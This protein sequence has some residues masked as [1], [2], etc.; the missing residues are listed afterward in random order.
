MTADQAFDNLTLTQEGAVLSIQINRPEVLNALD[1][2]TLNEITAAFTSVAEQESVRVV[3][4]GG[5]GRAFSAGADLGNPPSRPLPD[6]SFRLQRHAA[7]T[8][9]RAVQ[10]ITRCPAVTI[11]RTHSYV[12][13]GGVLLAVACDFRIGAEDSVFSLP[14]VRLGKPLSWGGTPLLIKEIGAAR[15]REMIMMCRPIEAAEAARIGL[16]HAVVPAT[17]LDTEVTRWCEQLIGFPDDSVAA[18]KQQF[19]RYAAATRLADLTETD[20]DIYV[21]IVDPAIK[22]RHGDAH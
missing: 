21:S 20:S 16:L 12:I 19:E 15:A 1:T 3:V 22:V 2:T 8:G 14:E 13:G 7:E 9:H 10:A 5:A 6:T 11:A 18:T 4:L 17:D